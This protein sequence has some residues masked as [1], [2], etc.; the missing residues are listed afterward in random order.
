MPLSVRRLV[1]LLVAGVSGA[2]CAPVAASAAPAAQVTFT[3]GTPDGLLGCAVAVTPASLRVPVET[4][5][6][7]VNRLNQQAELIVN[8]EDYGAVPA[9]HQVG[10]TVHRGPV[11]LSLVPG[12]QLGGHGTTAVV[13]V[14]GAPAQPPASPSAVPGAA[15]VPGVGDPGADDPG[16][17]APGVDD[18]GADDSGSVEVTSAHPVTPPR[19]ASGLLVLVAATTVLGV[20]IM[21]FRAKTA[22]RPASIRGEKTTWPRAGHEMGIS[23]GTG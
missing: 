23:R 4:T 2:L 5:V 11:G 8:D 14:T 19:R 12:C 7:V 6:L 18:P 16:A 15:G 9:G 10:V 3:G 17:D 22:L 13:E 1:A 21:A 20:S